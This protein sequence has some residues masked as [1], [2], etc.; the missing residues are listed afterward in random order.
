M[1]YNGVFNVHH[2]ALSL[3]VSERKSRYTVIF[4]EKD[5]DKNISQI[6][7]VLEKGNL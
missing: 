7:H 5:I 2:L 1:S 6:L 3:T 4:S